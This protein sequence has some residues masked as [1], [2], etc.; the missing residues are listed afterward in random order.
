MPDTPNEQ[1][2]KK[3]SELAYRMARILDAIPAHH[4]IDGPSA[5]GACASKFRVHV[6]GLDYDITVE[7]DDPR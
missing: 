1:V 2:R 7:M 5:S 3:S 6:H 4:V